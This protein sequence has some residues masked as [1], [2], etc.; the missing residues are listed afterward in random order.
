MGGGN[1]VFVDGHASCKAVK[2]L[3]SSDFGLAPDDGIDVD[4]TRL[5]SAAF[6]GPAK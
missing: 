2:W 5:Y 6:R 3:R 1:L 4:P